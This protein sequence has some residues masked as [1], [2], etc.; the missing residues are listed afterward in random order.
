MQMIK[1][2]KEGKRDLARFIANSGAKAVDEAL[3]VGWEQEKAEQKME[4]TKRSR[5]E[6]LYSQIGKECVVGCDGPWL[7][8]ARNLYVMSVNRLR[9]TML[10]LNF[11]VVF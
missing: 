6:I 2:R 8:M 3:S 11:R 9:I 5:T 7:Q 1:K 10:W 4:C